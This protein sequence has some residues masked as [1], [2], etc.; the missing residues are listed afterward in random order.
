MFDPM[1]T[2][3]QQLTFCVRVQL[4]I[5]CDTAMGCGVRLS[6]LA[7]HQPAV[8]VAIHGGGDHDAVARRLAELGF[9]AGEPVRLIA[10]GL[11]G[12][13]PLLVQ[14]GYTR[15]A[16]RRAEAARIEV[17]VEACA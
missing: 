8:V 4:R 7:R 14:V 9:V 13:E 11:W 3:Q 6:D 1:A 15:F 2:A 17:S 16:L 12:Q 5:I 10:T